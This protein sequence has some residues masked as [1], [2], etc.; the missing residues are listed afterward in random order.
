VCCLLVSRP[1]IRSGCCS[2]FDQDIDWLAECMGVMCDRAQHCVTL[3]YV[4]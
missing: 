3:C 2:T 4:L 1:A